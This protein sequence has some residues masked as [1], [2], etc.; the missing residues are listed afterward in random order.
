MVQRHRPLGRNGDPLKPRR[1]IGWSGHPPLSET[2]HGRRHG[3]ACQGRRRSE[4]DL[5][6]R[7]VCRGRYGSADIH[8]G[9]HEKR[10]E[11]NEVRILP[12]QRGMGFQRH[13]VPAT[14]QIRTAFI[15]DAGNG[16]WRDAFV[17]A[18]REFGEISPESVEIFIISWYNLNIMICTAWERQ[19]G[20]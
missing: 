10:Q 18:S 4:S 15:F 12:V 1:H 13:R 11:R 5:P 8:K 20:I 19:I 9:M 6:E 16:R 14:G 7:Y 17:I 3:N 2:G